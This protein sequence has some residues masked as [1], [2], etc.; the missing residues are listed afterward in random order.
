MLYEMQKSTGKRFAFTLIELLVVIAIIGIL[1]GLLL[2][3]ISR[4]RERGRQM[5]CIGNVRQ[6]VSGIFLYAT[7][8]K[9]RRKLPEPTTYMTVGGGDG[10]GVNAEDRPLYGYMKDT[11]VFECPSDRG[12]TWGAASAAHC[13][14]DLGNSYAYPIGTIGGIT[15]VA[16][17]KMTA[18]AYPAKKVLI[19]EPPMA[20]SE[21]NLT[22]PQNQ[23]HSSRRASVMGFMDGHSDLVFSNYTTVDP[24][25]NIYY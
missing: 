10:D 5:Q 15:N 22:N 18:F 9:N 24:E 8:Y 6:V 2:P 14:T 7:D 16:G 4:S 12:S 11:D 13:F 17:R 25:A 1:A 20:V 23:W 21:A 19:F 3:T